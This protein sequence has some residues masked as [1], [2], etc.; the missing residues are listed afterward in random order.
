M[1]ITLKSTE[2]ARRQLVKSSK[3]VAEKLGAIQ[4]NL[5][6]KEEHLGQALGVLG[7][8]LDDIHS[9]CLTTWSAVTK[10]EENSTAA[11]QGVQE[12]QKVLELQQGDLETVTKATNSIEI[13]AAEAKA[14]AAGASRSAT[15]SL[16][17]TQD[18][19]LANSF[20][21][22]IFKGVPLLLDGD[23]E[24]YRMLMLAFEE[25]MSEIGLKG[26]I[27]PKSLRRIMKRGDDKSN[28]PPHIRVELSSVHQRIQ[29]YDQIRTT[30]EVAGA[31]LTFTVAPDIPRYALKKHNALHKIAQIAR[32]KHAS[33]LTRVSMNNS[34]WPELQ[35]KNSQGE[36]QR[37]P[38]KLF[39][40][41][42]AI[43]NQRQKEVSDKKKA[44]KR[45]SQETSMETDEQPS[46]S[47][48]KNLRRG[49]SRAEKS[50]K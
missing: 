31:P 25:A 5:T 36:W 15:T 20:Y 46:T 35:I 38:E 39:E 24:P 16:N 11:L 34:K 1:P 18:A 17:A 40:E 49:P 23:R 28:R 6:S 47:A 48:G 19:Q 27:V 37:I 32:E 22:L 33:M 42:K 30:K 29:I 44:A 21:C 12:V 13:T 7:K 8:G 10:L 45:P 26:A 3:E 41:S 43:H 4:K 2:E 14:E 9:Q 50:K